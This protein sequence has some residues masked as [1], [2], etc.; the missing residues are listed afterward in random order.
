MLGI[1]LEWWILYVM[2]LVGFFFLWAIWKKATTLLDIRLKFL[3]RG[4]NIVNGNLE[5]LIKIMRDM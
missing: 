2:M 1:G 3:W 4:M 5:E